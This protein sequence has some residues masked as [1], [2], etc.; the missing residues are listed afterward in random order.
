MFS[1]TFWIVPTSFMIVFLLL[2]E[3]TGATIFLGASGIAVL[4][5]LAV[6]WR[7]FKPK[8][9]YDLSR[10]QEIEDREELANLDP[11]VGVFEFDDYLCPY[12]RTRYSMEYRNCPKCGRSRSS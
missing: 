10:L 4:S 8:G 9:R 3:G 1:K 7:D 12:C 2:F 11:D 5:T 6:L